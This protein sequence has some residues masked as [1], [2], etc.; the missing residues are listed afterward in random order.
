[1]PVLPPLAMGM[2]V[3]LPLGHRLQGLTHNNVLKYVY[4]ERPPEKEEEEEE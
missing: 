4:I 1:M 3:D 2:G